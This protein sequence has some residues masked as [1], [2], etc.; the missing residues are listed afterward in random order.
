MRLA[1]SSVASASSRRPA[2]RYAPPRLRYASAIFA[3]G[4]N[5]ALELLDR[6]GALPKVEQGQAQ[7]VTGLGERR[8]RLQR[9]PVHLHRAARIL[10]LPFRLAEQ[11]Q[12]LRLARGFCQSG[13]QFFARPAGPAQIEID[14]GQIEARRNEIGIQRQRLPELR[15][16]F[17]HE[18]RRAHA[19]VGDAE[20]HVTLRRSR[21]EREDRLE[22]LYRVLRIVGARHEIGAD[23]VQPVCNRRFGGVSLR[24][25]QPARLDRGARNDAGEQ[26][27]AETVGNHRSRPF[28]RRRP[29]FSDSRIGD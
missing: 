25:R 27:S 28:Y 5:D 24:S 18:V 22:L 6:F 7:V 29:G 13:F 16:R 10:Q 19:S 3:S 1:W 14:V 11:R 20:Q 26:N 4:L 12:K 2:S 15:D 23:A 9:L 17:T 8:V 21:I